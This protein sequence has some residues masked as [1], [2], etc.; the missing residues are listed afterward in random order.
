MGQ[1]LAQTAQ[2]LEVALYT[3]RLGLPEG[4]VRHP[5]VRQ[6]RLVGLRGVG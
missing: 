1:F 6:A 2:A 4:F 3:S 5:L